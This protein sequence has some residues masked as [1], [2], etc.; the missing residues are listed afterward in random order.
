MSYSISLRSENGEVTV[1]AAPGGPA[2]LPDGRFT[3]NGHH[4]KDGEV[5]VEGIGISLST[6]DGRG[7]GATS[8]ATVNR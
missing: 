8:N 2:H 4:V 1:E 3:I 5:G 6:S 7:T